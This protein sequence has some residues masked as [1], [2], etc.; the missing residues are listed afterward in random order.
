MTLLRLFWEFFQIG[1]FAVGGGMATLPFLQALADKT[2]WFGQSLITDMVAVSESTP[3]PIGINMATYVGNSVAGLPG[4]ICATLGV[5]LPS[6]IIVCIISKSLEAFRNSNVVNDIFYALRPAVTGLIAAAGLGVMQ[7]A[8]LQMDLYAET[9]SIL[10]V[11][12]W[13][14]VIYFVI[15]F[16]AIKKLKL[17]PIAYIAASVVIG[18]VLKF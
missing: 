3:G 16:I 18:I 13:M 10:S 12:N 5:I 14:K 17:H 8:M 1:L 9:G 15:A 4:G 6:I 7:L 11:I 2:G